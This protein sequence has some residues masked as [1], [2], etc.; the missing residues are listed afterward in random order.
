MSGPRPSSHILTLPAGN[1]RC[2]SYTQCTHATHAV[3]HTWHT[4]LITCRTTRTV[5]LSHCGSGLVYV[6]QT[7]RSLHTCFSG[8]Q[9]DVC[10]QW[11]SET[12]CEQRRSDKTSPTGN[13]LHLYIKRSVTVWFK[14]G[15]WHESLFIQELEN[16]FSLFLLWWCLTRP[17]TNTLSKKNCIC[18]FRRYVSHVL[19]GPGGAVVCCLWMDVHLAGWKLL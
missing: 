8:H 3:R 18:K 10:W 14:R 4:Y 1:Y 13:I 5:Y 2:G 15:I 19:H 7:S 9:P 6:S 12:V 16:V 11:N 17:R